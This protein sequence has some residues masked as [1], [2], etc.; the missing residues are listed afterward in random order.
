MYVSLWVWQS[1]LCVVEIWISNELKTQLKKIA[2]VDVGIL[3]HVFA[4][5]LEYICELIH[6]RCAH[7]I[8]NDFSI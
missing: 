1:S 4:S 6:E 7:W 5:F 2:I 8:R 3:E